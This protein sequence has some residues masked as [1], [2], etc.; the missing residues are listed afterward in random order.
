[1]PVPRRT[2]GR[3]SKG[4][5]DDV[6]QAWQAARTAHSVA[7]F[8]ASEIMCRKILMPIAVDQGRSRPTGLRIYGHIMI[9]KAG[10]YIRTGTKCQPSTR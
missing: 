7:A 1:V 4:L 10:G 8:T 2:S 6:K 9:W 3:S 5:P